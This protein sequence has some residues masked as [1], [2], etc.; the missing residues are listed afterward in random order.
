MYHRWYG[1]DLKILC[2]TSD[3]NKP[4]KARD[5]QVRKPIHVSDSFTSHHDANVRMSDR[6]RSTSPS[7]DS[8]DSASNSNDSHDSE[9]KGGDEARSNFYKINW[10]VV[11]GGVKMGTEGDR[12]SVSTFLLRTR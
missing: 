1:Y 8:Q 10:R 6:A 11:G 3:Q 4:E 12:K 2:Y 7:R 5:F 9:K